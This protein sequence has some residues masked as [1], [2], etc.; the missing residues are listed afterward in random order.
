MKVVDITEADAK[1][2]AVP[3]S[4]HVILKDALERVVDDGRQA[5]AGNRDATDTTKDNLNLCGAC[6]SVRKLG[7]HVID[8]DV[9]ERFVHP[10]MKDRDC[11]VEAVLW[12]WGRVGAIVRVMTFDIIACAKSFYLRQ[13]CRRF[14]LLPLLI[15]LHVANAN[16]FAADGPFR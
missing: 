11:S 14:N 15:V 4:A 5:L 12:G 9:W 13:R 3:S 8:G 10:Q 1:Q 2:M 7:L 6:A 16:V